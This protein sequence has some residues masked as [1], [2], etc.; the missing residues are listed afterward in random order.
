MPKLQADQVLRFGPYR[1]DPRGG[2]LWRGTLEVKLTPKA[3]AVLRH[4]VQQPGQVVSKEAFFRA[5]WADTVVSDAALTSCIQELRQA[6]HDE[7]RN[8]RYIETVH[9][10]G[11]RFIATVQSSR[12]KGQGSKAE[13]VPSPQHLAS[14]VVGRE[15]ELQ[16]LQR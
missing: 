6:L 5:V 10:R 16:Q 11:F 12:V 1:L 3:L 7:A 8:P 2:H 9:R 4:L 15:T 14:P 13:P